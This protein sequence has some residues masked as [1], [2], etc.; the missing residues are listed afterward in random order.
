MKLVAGNIG[1]NHCTIIG[2]ARSLLSELDRG[3]HRDSDTLIKKLVNR[4]GSVTRSEIYRTQL[5]S[6][7]RNRG[8]SIPELAQAAKK[9]VRQAYP[10]VHKDVIE[11]L[12][13]DYFIDALTDSEIRLRVREFD[14]KTLADAER[15]APN[16][17]MHHLLEHINQDL[18]RR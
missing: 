7:I 6:R 2:H 1:K 13:I 10:C 18:K 12:A 4:F 16:L 5:K 8:E 9:L 17:S 11:T 3:G 15:S 14:S